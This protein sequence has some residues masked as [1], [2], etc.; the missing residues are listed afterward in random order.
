M[1]L[2]LAVLT[3]AGAS[4]AWGQDACAGSRDLHLTNG[5]IHTLDAKNTMLTE[6]AIQDGKFTSSSRLSPCT[7]TI[8]LRGRTVVPGLIDNHNHIV[9]L[10]MRPGHDVRLESADSIDAVLAALK[11]KATV[12]PAGEWITSIGGFDINQFTPPPGMPRFPTLAYLD[13]A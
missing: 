5:R 12:V 3:L 8:N 7:R 1:K 2:F 4:A 9:L 6:I 11:L 13:S 10:G